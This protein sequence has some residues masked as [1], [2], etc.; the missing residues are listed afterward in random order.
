MKVILAIFFALAMFAPVAPAQSPGTRLDIHC[1]ATLPSQ[2]AVSTVLGMANFSQTYAARERLMRYA[3][4]ACR[5]GDG[6]VRVVADEGT[7]R[8][9]LDVRELTA[10][11]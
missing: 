10:I 3:Q 11:K 6:S 1:P 2:R 8:P 4:R 7:R 5:R 9:S